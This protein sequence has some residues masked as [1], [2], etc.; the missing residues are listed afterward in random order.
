MK[1][2][3]LWNKL[4]RCLTFCVL[5]AS[6][7]FG[8]FCSN[9]FWM[10]PRPALI[11]EILAASLWSGPLFSTAVSTYERKRKQNRQTFIPKFLHTFKNSKKT[12]IQHT[13]RC[14][15]DVWRQYFHELQEVHILMNKPHRSLSNPCHTHVCVNEWC[16]TFNTGEWV[17]DDY[18][19]LMQG[20]V[21]SRVRC[22]PVFIH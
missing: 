17:C 2:Y 19:S 21:C 10:D 14:T 13:R 7:K 15:E 9:Q 3:R 5:S 4:N 8:L 12:R 20:S 22:S 11:S 16:D 6:P 18:V 1:V